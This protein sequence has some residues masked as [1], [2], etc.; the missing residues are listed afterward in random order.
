MTL[1]T[2]PDKAPF[3]VNGWSVYAHPLFLDQLSRLIKEVEA[4]KERHPETWQKKNCAKRLAAIAKLVTEAIPTNPGDPKFR[5]GSALGNSRRHWFRAKFFQQYRLFYRY[6]N[7]AKV[8]VL[9]WVNDE[10]SL[11]S[12][13]SRTDVY[14][15]FKKMLDSGKPPDNFQTLMKEAKAA[16]MSLEN[17]LGAARVRSS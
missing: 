4:R 5:Q 11:R 7:V 15:T 6:N 3:V 12:Y 8:I 16:G 14:A 10:E 1:A 2:S 17:S 9:G 13:S